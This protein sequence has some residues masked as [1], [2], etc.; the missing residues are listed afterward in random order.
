[1]SS[2]ISKFIVFFTFLYT[3]VMPSAMMYAFA[4]GNFTADK[5]YH[6]AI[7]RKENIDFRGQKTSK[8]FLNPNADHE[9]DFKKNN[10]NSESDIPNAITDNIQT[11][12]DMLSSSPSELAEQAKSYALDKFNNTITSEAQKWLSQFGTARINFGLDKK[13]TLENNSL[14]LLLPLYDNKSDWLFF[15]QFGY[16]NKD[17]R[18]T[19]NV[20]LGGRYFYQNWMYGL[21]T[22]YDHDFTGKN[23]RLGLGGEIWSDYIKLSA[24]TYYRL[25]DWQQSQHFKDYH[26]RPANGYDIS[27]EFFLPA[28]P[29]LGAKLAYEQYFGDNVTLFNRDTKQKNPSLAKLGLTY[30]PIPLFTVGV[31]Y[32]QGERNYTETQFLANLNYK[33]GVPLHA[34]LLPEN[35]ASM[36]TL[37]GSRYD[38]VERNN[39]I[40]LDHVKQYKVVLPNNVTGYSHKEQSVAVTNN[41]GDKITWAKNQELKE[42]EKNGGKLSLNPDNK[43]A[44][45][46]PEY[47]SGT[48]KG[49]NYPINFEIL[50]NGNPQKIHHAKMTVHVRPFVVKEMAFTPPDGTVSSDGK[51]PYIFT[52]VMTYDT[53]SNDPLP[54]NVFIKNVQ[55]TTVPPI[56][57][58]SGLSWGKPDITS[59]TNKQGQLQA[60]LTSSKPIIGN[61]KVFLQMDGMPKAQQVATVSFEGS[62]SPSYVDRIEVSPPSKVLIADTNQVYEYKALI[63][64]SYDQTPVRH[65]KIT[66]VKWDNNNGSH[67]LKLKGSDTTDGDGYLTATLDMNSVVGA[68]DVLVT[69]AIENNAPVSAQRKVSFYPNG[70]G[71]RVKGFML[72]TDLPGPLYADGKSHYTMT[73]TITDEQH[74]LVRNKEIG[75]KWVVGDK[76]NRNRE[77]SSLILQPSRGV[78]AKQKTDDQGR[79][80]AT[81]SSTKQIDGVVVTLFVGSSSDTVVSPIATSVDVSFEKVRQ[82][83]HIENNSI[84]VEGT[85]FN[86]PADNEK[87]YTFTAVVVDKS[88]KYV[89]HKKITNV[90]W[91]TNKEADGLSLKEKSSTTNEKGELT[92]TLRSSMPIDDVLV[93][94][95]I[96]GQEPVQI[97]QP[98]AFKVARISIQQPDQ[99]LVVNTP[100]RYTATIREANGQPAKGKQVSWSFT[101]SSND[102]IKLTTVGSTITNEE[103]Q[104]TASL[105]STAAVSDLIVTVSA[106]GNTLGSRPVKVGWP[107]FEEL[108]LEQQNGTVSPGGSYNFKAKV[109]FPESD[110]EYWNQDVK[111]QWMIQSPTDKGLTLSPTGEVTVKQGILRAALESSK[112]LPPVKGAV[113]CLTMIGA[114]SSSMKCAGPVDFVAPSDESLE[115]KKP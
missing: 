114:P 115:I 73:A 58:T 106:E 80:T 79:I 103:G 4:E 26:E 99:D 24:N 94:L 30:T 2:Y 54:P 9:G 55:W 85:N 81:L 71:F 44:L 100:F 96:E 63:L 67:E 53:V 11:V 68:Q 62:S 31:D 74:N 97:N 109:S 23:Q 93:S 57:D 36:R 18:H 66:N 16:R 64:N 8:K 52:P 78:F 48:G 102:S 49:N 95:A 35:V 112:D 87:E 82:D 98:V 92:A 51:T 1:M 77:D 47:Q 105:I 32:K 13:G 83:Y 19:L 111:F 91:R 69:L 72:Y 75:V 90:V 43:I 39:N 46:F 61:V 5:T 59:T 89:P 86:L 17:S 76:Y 37:A 56:G 21:N 10:N 25:S 107:T 41:S 110:H 84:K 50:E 28:Y 27:G 88:G 70:S 14:D 40:I 33:L 104:V 3:L 6:Q 42:F 60:A 22:F 12:S 65:Q 29:N 15:S 34:Q 7:D 20:G 45:I 38:L 113:V 108:V 101:S